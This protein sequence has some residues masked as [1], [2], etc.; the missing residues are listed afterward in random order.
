MT[1]ALTNMLKFIDKYYDVP[2][3]KTYTPDDYTMKYQFNTPRKLKKLPEYTAKMN[4]KFKEEYD[5]EVEKRNT[6]IN[7]CKEIEPLPPSLV[8]LFYS[9]LQNQ[10]L[11]DIKT[12]KYSRELEEE[13]KKMCGITGKEMS[14]SWDHLY[15][16][17]KELVN[18]HTEHDKN[19]KYI[20]KEDSKNLLEKY[21]ILKTTDIDTFVNLYKKNV[22]FKHKSDQTMAPD[23]CLRWGAFKL[24]EILDQMRRVLGNLPDS[25]ECGAHWGAGG[26]FNGIIGYNEKRAS[27]KSFLAGGWNIQRL[28]IRCRITLLQPVHQ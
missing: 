25:C 13:F 20:L 15:Y 6:V 14:I 27:F 21:P 28:H 17:S 22:E 16:F 11:N 8:D 24:N 1:L 3:L 5:R 12:R 2:V 7:T 4:S 18:K 9:T 26:E 19:W 23:D 10:V